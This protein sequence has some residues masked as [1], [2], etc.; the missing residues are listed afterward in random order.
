MELIQATAKLWLV[1]IA[2]RQIAQISLDHWRQAKVVLIFTSEPA[3]RR[4]VLN[5]VA[6][7]ASQHQP[8]RCSLPFLHGKGIRQM[9]DTQDVDSN[10]FI[11]F[12]TIPDIIADMDGTEL[13]KELRHYVTVVDAV[14]PDLNTMLDRVAAELKGGYGVD[15]GFCL[16]PHKSRE[17]QVEVTFSLPAGKTFC[18]W[19][20][21]NFD[22]EPCWQLH[23]M[24][25]YHP[26]ANGAKNEFLINGD[27]DVVINGTEYGFHEIR[28]PSEAA[29][30]GGPDAFSPRF[31][32]MKHPYK[33]E[34]QSFQLIFEMGVCQSA[35]AFEGTL[36]FLKAA[37]GL[38]GMYVAVSGGFRPPYDHPSNVLQRR[39]RKSPRIGGISEVRG[40][41]NSCVWEYPTLEKE[42]ALEGARI[43]DWFFNEGWL[44]LYGVR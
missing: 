18:L 30:V 37:L 10:S 11:S 2:G 43:P 31:G 29:R 14:F 33:A 12:T 27:T 5:L 20:S 28:P 21:V 4:A 26:K 15:L 41:E 13:E 42:G 19:K 6:S 39:G 40:S 35:A 34:G 25:P 23:L 22:A 17:D 8:H 3:E 1:A 9:P 32:D 44:R 24:P 38:D 16:A 7:H 36:K